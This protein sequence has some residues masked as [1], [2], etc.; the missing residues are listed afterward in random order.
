MV[1]ELDRAF[2]EL[3]RETPDP[4]TRFLHWLRRP[5]RRWVRL[6]LGLLLVASSAFWFLPVIGIEFLP[7]GLLVLAQDLPVLRRPVGRTVLWLLHGWVRLRARIAA[8]RG[9]GG[10]PGQRGA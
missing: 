8:W 5:D 7:A 4:V 6:P 2:E 3:A 1:D 10:P 9:R